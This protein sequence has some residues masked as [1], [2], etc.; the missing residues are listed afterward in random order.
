MQLGIG[1]DNREPP[2]CGVFP[3]ITY[4]SVPGEQLGLE[5]QVK[6]ADVQV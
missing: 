4:L 6:L 1:P 3:A 5:K 2:F